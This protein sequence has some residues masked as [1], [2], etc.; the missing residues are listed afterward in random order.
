MHSFPVL[1]CVTFL[2]VAHQTFFVGYESVATGVWY[3]KDEEGEK[4]KARRE[5]LTRKV[6]IGP[7]SL[8]AQQKVCGGSMKTEEEDMSSVG[9]CFHRSMPPHTANQP[10][11]SCLSSAYVI[12]RH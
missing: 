2:A 4:E 3:P 7:N 9:D 10:S 5:R 1:V 8:L 11:G 12:T 6:L